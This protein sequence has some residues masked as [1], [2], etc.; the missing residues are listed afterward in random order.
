M[1]FIETQL[2]EDQP[3]YKVIDTRKSRTSAVTRLFM[4]EEEA[5]GF[6]KKEL[7]LREGA[8][9]RVMELEDA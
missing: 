3:W 2:G 8:A 9:Y 4:S 5:E 1:Y 6:A 7:K